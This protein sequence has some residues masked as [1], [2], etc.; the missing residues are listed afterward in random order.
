MVLILVSAVMDNLLKEF[1]ARVVVLVK[2]WV[3]VR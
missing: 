3:A 2:H 1:E